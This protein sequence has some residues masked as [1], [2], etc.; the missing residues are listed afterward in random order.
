[1]IVTEEF[2]VDLRS[3]L[4]LGEQI[5]NRL[6]PATCIFQLKIHWAE[7]QS[8]FTCLFCL[9][10]GVDWFDLLVINE[11]SNQWLRRKGSVCFRPSFSS[12]PRC[13]ECYE[14]LPALCRS[15]VFSWIRDGSYTTHNKHKRRDSIPRS[16][17]S[18]GF[19][20]TP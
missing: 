7:V 19:R 14:T 1:M 16:Q 18:G 6:W 8:R 2:A 10:T 3:C 20:P 15:T 9:V 11:T 12:P 17:Q 13:R 5:I 4:L